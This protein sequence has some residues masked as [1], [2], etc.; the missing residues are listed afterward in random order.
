MSDPKEPD[1]IFLPD[2][3]DLYG[4]LAKEEYDETDK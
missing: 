1:E 4:D 3:M 2:D